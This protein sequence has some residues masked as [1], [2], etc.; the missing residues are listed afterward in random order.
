MERLAQG[1]MFVSKPLQS[2]MKTLRDIMP[3]LK[4]KYPMLPFEQGTD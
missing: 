2:N 1:G 3:A 4:Q